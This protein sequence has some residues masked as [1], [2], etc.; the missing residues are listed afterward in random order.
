[1]A[2]DIFDFI[3]VGSGAAG[4]VGAIAASRC[5]LRPLIIEKADIWGGTTATSGGVLWVPQNDLMVADGDPDT[6]E[7]ARAYLHALVGEEADDRAIA[8]ADMFLQEAP[9]MAR[10]LAEEGVHWIRNDDHPDYYPDQPGWGRGRT[11]ESA[12]YDGRK[13]G[14]RFADMRLAELDVP[15]IVSGQFGTLTRAKT[16]LGLF[17]EAARTVVGHKIRTWLKQKP[18]GNGRALT[19][20]LM[21]I[22]MKRAIPLRLSTRLVDLIVEDGAV[23]GVVVESG[24]QRER[25]HAPAGVLLAAGGFARNAALRKELQGR[26]SFWTNAIP[27]DEG[28]AFIAARAIGAATDLTDDCWWMPSIQVGPDQNGLALGLRALPGSLIVDETGRRY[29]DEARCYMVTGKTMYEHGAADKRHWLIMDGK[30]LNRYIFTELSQQSIREQMLAQGYL[31]QAPTIAGL[32]E[33]CGLDPAILT[34]TLDRFNGFARSGHDADFGRG[35]TEYDR[36]WAD[37]RHHPNPSLGEIRNAPFWA[38]VI[39]PGDLGCNGGVKTDLHGRVLNAAD[40][41]ITGLY[42][43]GNGSASPFGKSYPG[44]GATIAAAAT[45]GYIAACHAGR[46]NR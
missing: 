39:R 31:V 26:D 15:A 17:A 40:R 37:P 36:Y 19:A 44:A 41:P 38:A 6:A 4:L 29:M 14:K 11:I 24:G 22:A 45:Y 42:A 32:A 34:A 1:M 21:E 10:M 33:R 30:Y 46:A 18:L 9:L 2:E 13:I 25:L 16:S 8:R 12:P 35:D 5:G 23:K 43:A 20:S 7:E 3:V 27:E 28:D